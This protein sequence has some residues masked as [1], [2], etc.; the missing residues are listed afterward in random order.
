MSHPPIWFYHLTSSRLQAALPKLLEKAY[1]A[2]LHSLV[3]MQHEALMDDVNECLWTYQE[4]SFL[5]HGTARDAHADQQPVLLTCEVADI[6][7]NPNQARMLVLLEDM[8]SD[9]KKGFERLIY[10]FD[11]ADDMAV[12]AARQRWLKWRDEGWP[13]VYWQQTMQGGWEKKQEV[14]PELAGS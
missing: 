11:G 14:Q 7:Q 6:E 3:L 10:M 9:A 2:E 8:D 4:R 12:Q 1:A 5:P 13:L